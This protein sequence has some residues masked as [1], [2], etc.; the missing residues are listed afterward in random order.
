MDDARS[1]SR[2]TT[3]ALRR[4]A[5]LRLIPAGSIGSIELLSPQLPMSWEPGAGSV[6]LA[7]LALLAVLAVTNRPRAPRASDRL[8]V[9]PAR[10]PGATEAWL[11]VVSGANRA[12]IAEAV[13][14][15]ADQML[16]NGHRVLVMDAGRRLELHGAFDAEARWG[17][18][19]CLADR[20]PVLGV[21]QQTGVRGLYLLA[22]GAVARTEDWSQLGRVLDEARPHFGRCILAVDRLAPRRAGDALLGRLAEGWWAGDDG[23]SRPA[24]ALSE[25]LGIA[26]GALRL[27]ASL[28]AALE[29]VNRTADEMPPWLMELAAPPLV[30][31]PE[32]VAGPVLEARVMDCDL[33]VRERLRFLMWMR[34]LEMTSAPARRPFA[35]SAPARSR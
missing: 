28:E 14:T 10:R 16:A 33:R 23:L 13:V 18:G 11:H 4:A 9:P 7:L 6:A 8:L 29:A 17:V 31:V 3:P 34:R 25:R 15:V 32:P 24:M 21:V 1:S 12:R 26:F 27:P 20:M 19:E 30:G 22:Q 2:S 35:D 5:A